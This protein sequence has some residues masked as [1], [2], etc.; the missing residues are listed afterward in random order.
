MSDRGYYLGAYPT[1]GAVDDC[2]SG[3]PFEMDDGSTVLLDCEGR[4]IVPTPPSAWSIFWNSDPADILG[5][6]TGQVAHTVGKTAG[7]IAGEAAGGFAGGVGQGAGAG[8]FA[9]LSGGLGGLGGA[10]ALIGIIAVAAIMLK[11]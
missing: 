4:V 6:A 8:L 11:R 2:M 5:H 7:A 1:L 10:V 9:G 3:T